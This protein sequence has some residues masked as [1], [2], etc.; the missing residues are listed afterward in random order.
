M[1]SSEFGEAGSMVS[2]GSVGN[3]LKNNNELPQ[4]SGSCLMGNGF[5]NNNSGIGGGFENLSGG[6]GLSPNPTGMRSAMG[7]NSLN[8]TGRVSTALMP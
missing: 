3:N 1:I 7:N 8:F 5:I 4:V 2:V 6:M